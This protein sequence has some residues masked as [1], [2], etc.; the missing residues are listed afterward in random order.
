MEKKIEKKKDNKQQLAYEFI[1]LGILD[2]KYFPGQR[3]IIDQLAVQLSLSPIPVREAIHRLEAEGLVKIKPY[4]GAIVTLIDDND[5]LEI[6][7]T[8]AVL[9]G[10]AAAMS[11]PLFPQDQIKQLHQI[12]DEMKQK[13]SDFDFHNF[14]NLNRE[15]HKICN[16][17][18]ANKYLNDKINQMWEKLDSV[19]RI[20]TKYFS[21]RAQESI[22]EHEIIISFIEKGDCSIVDIEQYIR[23]HHM[24]AIP[25]T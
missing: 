2:G 12:N 20:S 15:F 10:Y 21:T 23:N 18:S 7:S 24:R 19:R 3:L 11:I 25:R 6:L 14:I 13:L 17:Y 1:R 8:L 22:K 16:L 4:T 9:D 5:Y